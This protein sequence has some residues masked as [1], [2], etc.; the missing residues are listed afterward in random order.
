MTH[1]HMGPSPANAA[2]GTYLAMMDPSLPGVPSKGEPPEKKEKEKQE[3]L[4]TI[5]IWIDAP[6]G[7]TQP[8]HEFELASADGR[9][10]QRRPAAAAT[11]KTATAMVLKFT[12]VPPGKS[13]SLVQWL[14]KQRMVV[15]EH[16]PFAAIVEH[17][18]A[19]RTPKKSRPA[20][21]AGEAARKKA[22]P[23]AVVD[24]VLAPDPV[25]HKAE[26][27]FD[28]LEESDE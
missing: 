20:R 22:E 3:K 9:Y 16:L 28:E 8:Q 2:M 24:P 1:N 11:K 12:D 17:A 27:Y 21:R 4:Q 7:S 10:K 26:W 18:P 23:V 15:F 13:Y 5:E 25:E 6:S 14:G 19:G